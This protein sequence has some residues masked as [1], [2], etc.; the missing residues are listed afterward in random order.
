LPRKF[1]VNEKVASAG[2]A[3]FGGSAMPLGPTADA[4]AR[5]TKPLRLSGISLSQQSAY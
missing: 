5:W 1:A 2:G 3:R 4:T